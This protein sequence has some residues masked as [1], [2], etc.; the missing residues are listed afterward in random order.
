MFDGDEQSDG[1]SSLNGINEFYKTQLYKP[2]LMLQHLGA[3]SLVNWTYTETKHLIGCEQDEHINFRKT[4]RE[5]AT[6]RANLTCYLVLR[7][8][9]P[10]RDAN[11]KHINPST[12]IIFHQVCLL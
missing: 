6:N 2:M 9:S 11:T 4:W 5:Q 1:G 3:H 7:S 10:I 12:G 8:R